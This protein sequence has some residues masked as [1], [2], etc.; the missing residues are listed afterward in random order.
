MTKWIVHKFGGTSVADAERYRAAAEIVLARESDER[1][2]IVVSA[3]SGVTNGL[4]KSVELAASRD[5][6]YHTN[7]KQDTSK[8]SRSYRSQLPRPLRF[9]KPSSLISKRSKK[10]SAVSGSH[11]F[12][13]NA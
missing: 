9:A 4:I 13:P 11:E 5:E 7:F 12:H 3:M 1:V 10:S 2:G 6:S 8:R